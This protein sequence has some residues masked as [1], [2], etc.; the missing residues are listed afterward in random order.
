MASRC[1][2]AVLLMVVALTAQ[3]QK[4]YNLT[5]QQVRIDSVAPSFSCAIPLSGAYTDSVYTV[6]ISYPEYIDMTAADIARYREIMHGIEPPATPA[7]DQHIV[8]ARRKASLE[9]SFCPVVCRQGKYQ[10]L[11]SFMLDVQRRALSRSARKRQRAALVSVEERYAANSVLSTGRWA[12]IRVAESGV[13]QLTESLI[14]R[15]GFT[16][17]SKVHVYGMGGALIDETLTGESLQKHDDLHEVQLYFSGG[18]RLFYAQGPVSWAAT[19]TE[20]R[21]RNPYSQYGYY[22]ITQTDS[23]STPVDSATFVSSFYPSAAD[24]HWLH[25]TDNYAWY[26]GGRNLV[27][28]TPVS[29]GSTQGY[30]LPAFAASQQTAR[31][32]VAVTA[33]VTSS[34]EISLGDS[35]LG[36]ESI[37]PGAY[38]KGAAITKTYAINRYEG[39][40]KINIKTISGGPARLDYI[41]MAFDAPAAAPALTGTIPEPEYVHNITNQNHHADGQADMVII[42]P[43]SQKLLAQAQRLKKLHEERDSMRVTIVPADELYNEFS[44]GTPD[45]SAYRHYMKMLYDRAET[46]SD[47][48]RYLLLLG[49]CVWDNRMLTTDTRRLDADD[50]LL[51]YESENSFSELYCYVNDGFYTLLDDGEGANMLRDKEDIA[52]GRMPVTTADAAKGIIDKTEAYI[53]NANAGAWQNVLMFMGDD[54]NQNIHMRDVDAAAEQVAQLHPG[55]HIKKVMWDAYDRESSATGH[56]YPGAAQDIKQQMTNGALIMDYSGHGRAEQLSHEKVVTISDFEQSRTSNLPLWITASCDI[57]AFDGV[58]AT[59]GETAVCNAKGGAVAFYGTTRTV[60]TQYNRAINMAYLRHVLTVTN[61][62][63][64]ALGEAQ[65]LAKN[66]MI[67]TGQDVTANKLQYALLG[68][69]ALSLAVPVMTAVIDSIN[70]LV[71]TD[72]AVQLQ[73]GKV[74]RI[75]GH[76][77][78]ATDFNGVVTAT[79]RDVRE[80][81]T[82]RQNN[83]AEAQEAFTYYDRKRIIY[84]GADS[85]RAGRFALTFAVP[86]DISYS[87]GTGLINI[88]AVDNARQREAHGAFN[89]FS[90]AG[91]DV[92]TDSIGPSIYCYLNSPHFTNGGKV[93]TTPYFVAEISDEDGINATGSGIGHDLQLT[94]DGDMTKTYTLNDNFSFDFGT[95]TRGTTYYNI[96]ELTEGKHTLTFRAWDVLNNSSTAR[97][98]FTVVR[99]LEPSI[100]SVGLSKNPATTSTTFIVNHDRMGSQMD[101]DIEV[102]DMTGRLL[103]THSESGVPNTGAYTVDWDLTLDNGGRLQTGV[104]LYRVKAGSDGSKKVSKAKKL[105]VIGNN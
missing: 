66:E 2:M 24:Y 1:V 105:V 102:F 48:P 62:R 4:F 89:R 93:N 96:P 22:F 84:H 77:E 57:M 17:I 31:V 13:Y 29:L 65:R 98:D 36:T 73:V 43:T 99:G 74:V 47:L 95:Y 71:V 52:V 10:L 94:I 37:E 82:C 103:W 44:S 70:G 58:D 59:I 91:G 90:V 85:V 41:S 51:C 67:T 78:Q 76:I 81:V 53:T 56:T 15:A 11:V 79:V 88:Y 100:F 30:T 21:T 86:K 7:I 38:D 25:E 101:V 42:I 16:D 40:Q 54:G 3:A 104:Y 92:V 63:R 18:K 23:E 6:A 35:L 34:V 9:L 72:A 87:D 80:L 12:K 69:P 20:T 61:G 19:D 64:T 14:R 45:A 83:E 60:Q 97:L 26:H 68:D 75:A 46:E 50:Y 55:Y 33:G 8:M 32:T 49:D 39:S 28:N 27:E 5:A